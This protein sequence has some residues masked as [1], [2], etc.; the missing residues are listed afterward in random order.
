[1][2]LWLHGFRRRPDWLPR[3]IDLIRRVA[4]GEGISL[5]DLFTFDDGSGEL[6]SVVWHLIWRGSLRIDL[7]S[8]I[9]DDSFVAVDE[10]LWD[11]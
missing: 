2:L 3:Q 1:N 8:P 5:R 9:D 7:L 6:K 11:V 10:E 4:G